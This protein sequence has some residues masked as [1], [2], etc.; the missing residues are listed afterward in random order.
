[1]AGDIGINYYLDSKEVGRRSS[2]RKSRLLDVPG[3]IQ[4]VYGRDKVKGDEC[5]IYFFENKEV[6]VAFRDTALAK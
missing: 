1:M 4:I 3:L 5:G 2:E 6:L